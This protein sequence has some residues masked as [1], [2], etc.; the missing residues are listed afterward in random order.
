M[1]TTKNSKILLLIIGILLVTNIAVITLLLQG[2]SANSHK[3]YKS[4]MTAYLQNEIK[5]T[6]AQMKSYE[7]LKNT[8]SASMKN[9]FD[10]LRAEKTVVYK[11]LGGNA[12][13]DSAMQF[14]V[15]NASSRQLS[16]E[17]M[18]LNHVK[19]VRTIC[20]PAQQLVFD[21]GFYKVMVRGRRDFSRGKK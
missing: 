9:F 6:D 5:F 1:S 13:N 15:V 10:T 2:R 8:H 4:P 7:A 18:M 20:T 12:F 21:T 19:D 16:M 11:Q 3:D 17:T 14:A